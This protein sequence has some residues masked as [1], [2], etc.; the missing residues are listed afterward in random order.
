M[1]VF[2]SEKLLLALTVFCALCLSVFAETGFLCE[3]K[4]KEEEL[5]LPAS[6]KGPLPLHNELWDD[7][8]YLPKWARRGVL[9]YRSH[10]RAEKAAQM[11]TSVAHWGTVRNVSEDMAKAYKPLGIGLCFRTESEMFFANEHLDMMESLRP[12]GWAVYHNV[13]INTRWFSKFPESR[14]ANRVRR[15]GTAVIEYYGSNWVE[16]RTGSYL[17]PSFRKMRYIY[18][19][20][21]L[22]G[23]PAFPGEKILPGAG[24]LDAIW[25][26][27]PGNS[28]LCYSEA[29]KEKYV[30]DFKKKFPEKIAKWSAE[31][32]RRG[33]RKFHEV[34]LYDPPTLWMRY[35]DDEVKRWWEKFWADSYAH[36]NLWN[37][38]TAQE[39]GKKAGKDHILIGGNYKL[40][41]PGSAW[42]YYMF[43]HGG[44]DIMGPCETWQMFSNKQAFA[45]KAALAASN[46]KMTGMWGRKAFLAESLACL[47]I[48][49]RGGMS[50]PLHRFH[51]NNRDMYENAKPG[52][53][54]AVL[55]CLRENIHQSEVANLDEFCNQV[56][57]LGIPLE[58]ITEQHLT[59]PVL[60]NF[61]VLISCGM[62]FDEREVGVVKDYVNQGGGLLL[63]G[64]NLAPGGKCISSEFGKREWKNAS[65]ESGKG[66]VAFYESQ[67]IRTAE[68]GKALTY[69]GGDA[70]RLTSPKEDILVNV[71]KQPRMNCIQVH[72]VNYSGKV[73]R[74]LELSLPG[75]RADDT[76]VLLSPDGC[77]AELKIE[78]RDN[79]CRVVVPELTRYNVVVF[80]QDRKSAAGLLA[81]NRK[82]GFRKGSGKPGGTK[83]RYNS[84]GPDSVGM[85]KRLCLL[86]HATHA[87]NRAM[88][89]DVVGPRE[90]DAKNN[91]QISLVFHRAAIWVQTKSYIQQ[92]NIVFQ[93][94][95]DG[96]R[97]L[98]PVPLK[99]LTAR[100]ITS[101]GN[102]KVEVNWKPEEPGLYQGYLSY[103]YVNEVFEG[104]PDMR[105]AGSGKK[106][107]YQLWNYFKGEP[108]MKIR[109]RDKLRRF[110]IK[111]N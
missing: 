79:K 44:V 35:N 8:E 64:E 4:F 91:A 87:P 71:L 43:A 13:A 98:V 48:V 3:K 17:H 50:D 69:L 110:V 47:G 63:I 103:I 96:K 55:F 94:E 102:N 85:D 10:V 19:A 41:W 104:E 23:Q 25:Y 18:L 61:D 72:L 40:T 77:F 108:L 109:Y 53:K 14:L 27:N 24:H 65:F 88:C 90:I 7:H 105:P 16:R 34:W 81:R 15:D 89:V 78:T 54:V 1:M 52:G 101:K 22:T 56:W 107:S 32:T 97:F 5:F 92:M 45:F 42:D 39:L 66:K 70:Y 6:K 93:R 30:A 73:Q 80:T 83:A 68:L 9:V 31:K 12:G 11:G 75:D 38:F 28:I 86:R 2:R 100:E 29:V 36:Y 99:G 21:L 76:A 60:K 111:V 59:E 46:G 20:N 82:L 51:W 62:P 67:T 37:Y 49:F 57:S 26:D 84:A 58:V 33:K 74:N 106:T 95:R